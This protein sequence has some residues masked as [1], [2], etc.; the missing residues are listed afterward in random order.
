LAHAFIPHHHLSGSQ[1]VFSFEYNQDKADKNPER[2]LF[3]QEKNEEPNSEACG[4]TQKSLLLR[5]RFRL[6]EKPDEDDSKYSQFTT[7]IT[8][9]F[10]SPINFANV[11]TRVG[12]NTPIHTRFLISTKTPRAPPVC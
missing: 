10:S 11:F 9:N 8:S 2:S 7:I 3:C 4:I 6:S 1:V 5:N 12:E